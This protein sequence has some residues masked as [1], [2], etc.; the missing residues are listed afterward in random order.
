MDN[1]KFTSPIIPILISIFLAVI[2]FW[3][4]ENFVR[5]VVIMPLLKVL[6]FVYLVFN[7][8][9]Q[10]AVWTG[11]ILLLVVLSMISIPNRLARKKSRNTAASPRK[12]PV[13]RWVQ[14]IDNGQRNPFSK[15]LL[16]KELKRLSR[17]LLSS[18]DSL[19]SRPKD[20]NDLALPGEIEAFFNVS[21]PAG[22][23]DGFSLT[24]ENALDLDPEVVIQYLEKE[25]SS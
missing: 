3:I 14:M 15:W 22:D 7:S 17:K 24:S 11:M 1:P 18:S 23:Q 8:I 6:W 2:L 12:G 9:P 16:A 21:Q 4:T 20:F 5:T 13:E 19:G 10:G 25:L